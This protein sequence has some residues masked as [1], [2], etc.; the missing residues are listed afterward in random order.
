MSNTV[1]LLDI[2]VL[3]LGGALAKNGWRIYLLHRSGL[4]QPR[5]RRGR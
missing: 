1:E 3:K 2:E 4:Q 5:E